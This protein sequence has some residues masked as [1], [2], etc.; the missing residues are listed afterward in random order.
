[1]GPSGKNILN[2]MQ[3]F[4]LTETIEEALKGAKNSRRDDLGNCYHT[5][6]IVLFGEKIEWETILS[7]LVDAGWQLQG[8]PVLIEA[9][10]A[11]PRHILL[12]MLHA[13][14]RPLEIFGD[15]RIH[16]EVIGGG[17]L[18]GELRNFR[19]QEDNRV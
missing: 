6:R 3:H 4:P 12:A 1:M 15:L 19:A 13:E 7:A 8:A 14:P 11:R 10:A 5:F 2:K 18:R 9:T 16:G 17:K